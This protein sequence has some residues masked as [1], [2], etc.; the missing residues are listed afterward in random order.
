MSTDG[1]LIAYANPV[2]GRDDEFRAW[3]WGEHVA[4]VLAL[5]GFVSAESYRLEDEPS[6]IS[7]YRYVT[8]YSID[9]SPAE[10]RNR[11]FSGELGSSDAMDTSA[12]FVGPFVPRSSVEQA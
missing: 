9:G 3:Y 5:P 7:P 8:V 4:Q 6:P 12:V 11:M 2:D 1:I 10:A